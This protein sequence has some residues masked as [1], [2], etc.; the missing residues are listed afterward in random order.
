ME[1]RVTRKFNDKLLRLKMSDSVRTLQLEE[2]LKKVKQELEEIH[3]ETEEK[4]EQENEELRQTINLQERDLKEMQERL[5]RLEETLTKLTQF[6]NSSHIIG[7]GRYDV[8]ANYSDV[9]Q[10]PANKNSSLEAE[11]QLPTG[12]PTGKLM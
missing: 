4:L 2:K 8:M 12:L 9:T 6:V 1:Q 11:G 10:S 5:T 7:G 3:R